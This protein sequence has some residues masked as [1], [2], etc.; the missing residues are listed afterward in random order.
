MAAVGRIAAWIVVAGLGNACTTPDACTRE[1]APLTVS[2]VE[3]DTLEVRLARTHWPD[4]A[5]PAVMMLVC[6]DATLAHGRTHFIPLDMKA[7]RA[8]DARGGPPIFARIMVIDGPDGCY[9][10]ACDAA[11]TRAHARKKLG[12]AP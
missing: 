10:G 7:R 4:D 6:A 3:P 8:D 12:L 5:L 1:A 11:L 2:V 9:G